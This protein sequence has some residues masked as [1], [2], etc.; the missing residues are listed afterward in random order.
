MNIPGKN[1]IKNL[2]QAVAAKSFQASSIILAYHRIFD[3]KT[4]PQLLCVSP[5]NFEEQLKI[6]A[7]NYYPISLQSLQRAI[8]TNTI[9]NKSVAITFDDGYVD[10]LLYAKPLLEKYKIPATVFI[11]THA[12]NQ[13]KE[14]WW[15]ELER[16]I[17]LPAALPQK[18]SLT[19]DKKEYN[20]LLIN[21]KKHVNYTSTW[22]VLQKPRN[23]R[24]K[25]YLDLHKLLKPLPFAKKEVI[26]KELASWARVSDRVRPNYHVMSQE[27]LRKLSQS[28]FIEIGSHT[29][30]HSNLAHQTEQEQAYEITQSKKQLE[31]IIQKPITSFSYPFGTHND[32]GKQL[33]SQIQKTGYALATANYPSP[34]TKN[35]DPF[36]LPRYLVRNWNGQIFHKKVTQW[37]YEK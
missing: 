9:P 17:L 33:P 4:D 32:I 11:S 13:K 37:F 16:I 35:I 22:D 3:P 5:H 24:F 12:I 7:Q 30:T 26:L 25:L 6:I 31:K 14:L 10:N 8:K 27:E 2:F 29:V 34:V 19:I 21:Q 23:D 20:W 36:L 1:K 18:L 15:D 28:P